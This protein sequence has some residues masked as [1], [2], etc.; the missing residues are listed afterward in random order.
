[1]QARRN[2]AVRDGDGARLRGAGLCCHAQEHQRPV[3]GDRP[4]VEPED[5]ERAPA[6]GAG[7][8]G[9]PDGRGVAAGV[10]RRNGEGQHA[11][12]VAVRTERADEVQSSIEA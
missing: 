11:V 8:P 2:A 3:A 6:A 9:T 4:R 1:M 12:A 10:E 7:A 5:G